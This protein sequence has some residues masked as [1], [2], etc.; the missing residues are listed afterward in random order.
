[1]RVLLPGA[2]GLEPFSSV[3]STALYAAY[4]PPSGPW[5]RCNMVTTLDGSATGR[6]GVAGS[7]N[8][9]AD[10]VVFEL[11][12]ASAHAVVVGAGTVR[13]EGYPALTLD[14]E[15]LP[16]RRARGLDDTFPLV[17]VTRRGDVPPTLLDQP[18]GT[19]LLATVSAAQGL[20]KAREHLGPEHVIV[21]GDNEVNLRLLVSQLHERGWSQLLTEGG[22]SLL[23]SF[24]AAGL[25]DELCF[26]VSPRVVGGDGPR[27]IAAEGTPSDLDLG[28]LLEEDGTLLGRWFVGR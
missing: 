25:L 2:S 26:T 19:V 10:H 13:A 22:P 20:S 11:L 14:P 5:L 18:A 15:L 4:A 17:A 7:I 1:M 16:L 23:G 6:D 12:R 3:D 28:L 27:P 21:C 8:T 9:K 24:M